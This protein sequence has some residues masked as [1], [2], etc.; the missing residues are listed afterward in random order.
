MKDGSE[1]LDVGELRLE[2]RPS[3]IGLLDLDNFSLCQIIGYFDFNDFSSF[4]K[5]CKRI[6]TLSA[7]RYS[8][9]SNV[10]F[11]RICF[12]VQDAWFEG[13]FETSSARSFKN[14]PTCALAKLMRTGVNLGQTLSVLNSDAIKTRWNS[15]GPFATELFSFLNEY[16]A[17]EVHSRPQ[18]DWLIKRQNFYFQIGSD[19]IIIQLSKLYSENKAMEI[20]DG[21]V[22]SSDEEASDED[23]DGDDIGW[24]PVAREGDE[25]VKQL[26]ALTSQK[27]KFKAYL[28]GRCILIYKSDTYE[29]SITRKITDTEDVQVTS[30][31]Q[32]IGKITDILAKILPETNVQLRP[33]YIL[34][35]FLSFPHKPQFVDVPGLRFIEEEKNQEPHG[36]VFHENL[37]TMRKNAIEAYHK[38]A[39]KFILAEMKNRDL[40]E[41]LV[42]HL[43]TL[44]EKK[45]SFFVNIDRCFHISGKTGFDL[46]F[47]NEL[48]V[49]TLLK[50]LDFQ[51]SVWG[52][53]DDY[54]DFRNCVLM[55]RLPLDQRMK[56]V[57]T[58]DLDISPGMTEK[59]ILRY[60][61]YIDDSH[62]HS[63]DTEAVL[64]PTESCEQVKQIT[65]VFKNCLKAD[66]GPEQKDDIITDKVTAKF[67]LGAVKGL[68]KGLKSLQFE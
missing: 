41:E 42:L 3:A 8:W 14:Y 55:F 16:T 53:P 23:D 2:T 40:S 22:E 25:Y 52:A 15:C 11:R 39:D 54:D 60:Q 1:E 12:L 29:E 4:S 13:W 65:E 49:K 18:T 43:G 24:A 44:L 48:A 68:L 26:I 56:A 20:Q 32:G 35:L 9:S 30:D 66:L 36:P 50:R 34:D 67:L 59:V 33:E 6:N 28:N 17:E 10:L 45:P 46:I 64:Q 63:W 21:Y 37:A 5:T 31:L 51:A 58:W 62:F 61:F 38:E 7:D 47:A 27:F 57:C 19:K